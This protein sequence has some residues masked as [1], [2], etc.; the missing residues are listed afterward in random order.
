MQL[1]TSLL[2]KSQNYNFKYIHSMFQDYESQDGL[3]VYDFDDLGKPL[4]TR[5]ET[6]IA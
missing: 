2:Y 5:Q 4:K 3:L 6:Y 1:R